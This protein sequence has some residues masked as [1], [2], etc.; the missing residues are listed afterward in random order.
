MS[1]ITIYYE[2]DYITAIKFIMNTFKT[3]L[4]RWVPKYSY[5][6]NMDNRISDS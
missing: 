1:T 5:F 2:P 4:L 6:Q 3:K